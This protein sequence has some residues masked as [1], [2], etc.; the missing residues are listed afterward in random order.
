MKKTK[1][2]TLENL[3]ETGK[4]G[5]VM[6]T[7]QVRG[8]V[9]RPHNWI[10][11]ELEKRKGLVDFE[12]EVLPNLKEN[13]AKILKEYIPDRS[14]KQVD[15]SAEIGYKSHSSVSAVI[16]KHLLRNIDEIIMLKAKRDE[17]V[18]RYGGWDNLNDLALCLSE[19]E[20]GVLYEIVL[21]LNPQAFM[22]YYEKHPKVSVN[23]V[24]KSLEKNLQAVIDRKKA[25]EDF[26]RDNGG[27]D[28][29]INEFGATLSDIQFETMLMFLMDYHYVSLSSAAESMGIASFTLS[30]RLKSIKNLL[31]EYNER[32]N[33]VDLLIEQAGGTEKVLN[34][35]YLKLDK[36]N[37]TIFE[38]RF[39]AYKQVSFDEIAKQVNYSYAYVYKRAEEI[40]RKF[41]EFIAEAQANEK[42]K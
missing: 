41:N 9:L 23:Y 18:S 34:E 14:K 10:E 21:S 42:N 19:T 4:I 33:Q 3:V 39:L 6:Q 27:E 22:R 7:A 30:E 1:K 16:R 20:R 2:E 35:F 29:L 13:Y 11:K 32:K 40:E 17:F 36:I 31:K 12:T 5:G 15:Y 28:F 37:R 25:S 38:G 8:T 26:V 24:E